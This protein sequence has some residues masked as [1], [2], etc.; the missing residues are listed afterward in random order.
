MGGDWG[1]EERRDGFQAG[2]PVAGGYL[3]HSSGCE[4]TTG[5]VAFSQLLLSLWL[6]KKYR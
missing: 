6:Y 1:D 3:V 4:N 2:C 5:V